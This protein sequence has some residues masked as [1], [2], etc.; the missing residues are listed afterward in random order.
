MKPALNLARARHGLT[1]E[2]PSVGSVIVKNDE[3]ISIGQTS[4]NGRLH[5]ELIKNCNE[6]LSGSTMYITLE[7]CNH[8][9]KTPPCT[10]EIIKNKIS[11]VIYSIEDID[12]KVKGKL[13]NPKIENIIIKRIVESDIKNFIYHTFNRKKLPYVTGNGC[14]R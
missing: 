9:G 4:Y 1:G 5:S 12:Q 10:K 13:S 11:H 3:I 14:I 6:N 7:P 8:Y 2:N